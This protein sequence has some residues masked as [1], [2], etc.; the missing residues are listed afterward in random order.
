LLK[1]FFKAILI[2]Q[3][4]DNLLKYRTLSINERTIYSTFKYYGDLT[5]HGIIHAHFGTKLKIFSVNE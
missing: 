2:P 1:S 4:A 5:R 3:T